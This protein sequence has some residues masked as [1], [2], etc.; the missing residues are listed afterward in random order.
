MPRRIQV[1]PVQVQPVEIHSRSNG[2][3]LSKVTTSHVNLV[4]IV[5]TNAWLGAGFYYNTTHGQAAITKDVIE[6]QLE[7]KAL[8]QDMQ[9]VETR[10]RTGTDNTRKEFLEEMKKSSEGINNLNIKTARSEVLLESLGKELGR[11]VAQL[12]RLTA[13]NPRQQ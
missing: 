4:L 7:V 6:L 5:A 3:L 10:Q 9:A 11:V 12:E 2:S 8:K 13:V 1:Q